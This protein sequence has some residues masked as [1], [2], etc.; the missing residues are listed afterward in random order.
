MPRLKLALLLFVKEPFSP[1]GFS[2]NEEAIRFAVSLKKF[3]DNTNSRISLF[4]D[5]Y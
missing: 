4:W 5:V 1:L 2:P 3:L